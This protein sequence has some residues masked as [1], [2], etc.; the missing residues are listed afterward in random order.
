M[1]K[2]LVAACVALAALLG[3]S[4]SSLRTRIVTDFE[5]FAARAQELPGMTAEYG[6]AGLVF[7]PRPAA[8]ISDVVISVERGKQP[9]VEV[10]TAESVRIR[11]RLLPLLMGRVEAAGVEVVAPTLRLEINGDGEHLLS[12]GEPGPRTGELVLRLLAQVR[13]VIDGSVQLLDNSYDPPL[14]LELGQLEGDFWTAANGGLAFTVEAKPAG[15]GSVSS[16]GTLLAG[17]GPTGGHGLD[18]EVALS[19]ASP[20]LLRGAI[21][22]WLPPWLVGELDL[23]I[24]GGGFIGERGNDDMPAEPLLFGVTGSVGVDMYGLRDRLE[25]QSTMSLDDS[26]L[27][28]KSAS[29]SAYGQDFTALGWLSRRRSAEASMRVRAEDVELAALLADFGLE[30][31]LVPQTTLTGTLKLTGTPEATALRYEVTADS[32]DLSPLP[33]LQMQATDTSFAGAIHSINADLSASFKARELKAGPV[34]LS[35]ARSGLVWWKDVFRLNAMNMAIWD[36]TVSVGGAVS[37]DSGG[38]NP[39]GRDIR[40]SV[41]I[42]DADVEALLVDVSGL[43]G[44]QVSGALDAM[45]DH[46]GP[47]RSQLKSAG[48]LALHDGVLAGVDLVGAARAALE[49]RPYD[50]AS[51]AAAATVFDRLAM[52]FVSDGDGVLIADLDVRLEG[53]RPGGGRL[54]GAGRLAVSDR[55]TAGMKPASLELDCVLELGVDRNLRVPLRISGPLSALRVELDQDFIS[56]YRVGVIP[57]V[58]DLPSEEIPMELPSLYTHFGR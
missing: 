10:L 35:D 55:A 16:S 11:P 41:V 39:A 13:S 2:L 6:T 4:L 49:G 48:R 56:R 44:L 34:T 25:L 42:D 9:A 3:F 21:G 51:G 7:F 12:S 5:A 37:L 26:R 50:L 28:V 58:A 19:G 54:S 1:R 30:G 32:V 40:L 38:E 17:A 57:P 18:F 22:D 27:R 47:N 20:Q 46:G 43:E 36:G 53:G 29:L 14:A 31:E 33:W 23:D 45:A 8:E 15:G 24:K 52:D